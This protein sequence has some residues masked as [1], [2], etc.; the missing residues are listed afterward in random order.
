MAKKS[1]NKITS[2]HAVWSRDPLTNLP[3]A[4]ERVQDWIKE[5]FDSKAGVFYYDSTNNRFLV[6]ADEETRDTYLDNPSENASLLLG[7]FDAPFNYTASISLVDTNSVN[8][9][10]SGSTGNYIKAEFDVVNKS[11]SSVGENVN[12]T[13]TFRNGSAQTRLTRTVAYGSQLSLNI[14]EYLSVG[15]NVITIAAVGQNTLAATSIGL[16]YYCINLELND[17]FDI[18]QHISPTGNLDI[19]FNIVG[20]GIKRLQWYI[21]GV[22]VPYD[23]QN[24]DVTASEASRVKT[25]PLSSYGLSNGRHNLQYRAY[26]ETGDGS[27]FYS[28]TLYRDFIVD[29]GYLQDYLTVVAFDFPYSSDYGTDGIIDALTEPIPIYGATQYLSKD[30]KYAVNCPFGESMMKITLGSSASTYSVQNGNVYTYSLQSFVS[31]TTYLSFEVGTD[32]LEFNVSFEETSYSDLGEVT[33]GLVF[34]MDKGDSTNT[35]D[36]RNAWSYGSYSAVMTGFSW[37]DR[38]GWTRDG[39]LIPEGASFVTNYAPLAGN[40]VQTGFTAEFEFETQ[41]VLDD[42]EIICD[43]R[44]N[45]TGLLITASEASITSRGGVSVSTK[46]KSGVPLRVSFVI[47]PPTATRNKNLLFIY[48]DGI[49]AGAMNYPSSDS[50]TSASYL[51]FA[52]SADAAILLKQVR[53][54]N[55]AL[56]SNEILNNFILYRPTTQELVATYDRNDILDTNNQPSEDKLAAYTPIIIVTGDVEKLMNFDRSNKG[57]YVK[58][59]KIEIINNLDPTKN[60]TIVNA[61]MRCQ[62]TSSM[63]YPRK[64]FRFYL[65]KDSADTTVDSYATRVFDY[66]GNELT[67]GDRKYAFKEGAQPVS[68]WCLK[69]DYAESSST[70]NTGVARLWNTVMKNAVVNN[71]DSRHYVLDEYPSSKTPCRTLAQHAALAE[72]FDKDVRTTVD[73]F[74]IVLFYHKNESDALICLGKYNWNNDKSTESVYGFVD[75]PGFDDSNVECWEVVNGD[76]A[77]NQ[78]TDMT[79]WSAGANNGGWQDSFEA[80]Y[81]DDSGKASEATRAEGALKTVCFWIN[82]TNGASKVEDGEIV[83]DDA[84]LMSTF[85][86]EKWDHLDVYKVAAYYVYLMR[87]GGVD[88]TVKNAMFTTEDGIHWFY[89]NYDNDTI[90]GVRNDGL[91]KFGYSIDRQSKDPDN[92]NA[93]CYAGHDSVLWNNLEADTEFMAIVKV[94]DQALFDAGLTYVNVIKMFNEEQ[95]G[96]WSERLHNYDYT[97]KYLDVWL[98]DQNMQLEK[99]QGPRRTHRE[100]WLSNRFAIYDAKNMTGQ[101]LKSFVSIKPST[102][103]A[104]VSGDVVKVTPKVDGQVF[105]WRLGTNGTVYSENGVAGTEISFDLYAAGISYYIGGSLFFFNA[106]YMQKIDFSAIATHIQ[107]LS[108]AAVNSDVFPTYLEEIVV[109]DTNSVTNTSMSGVSNLGNVKYL[110]KF[111]MCNCTAV[112]NLDLSKNIYLEEVDLRGSTSL[113]AVSFPDAAPISTIKMPTSTQAFHGKDLVNLSTFSV[114][115]NGANLVDIRAI[116]C[117]PFTDSISWLKTWRT[118]KTDSFLEGCSVYLEGIDWLNVDVDDLI[119]LGKV[120]NLTLKGKIQATL[121]DD[122]EEE[123]AAL[124]AIYGEHCFDSTN[125]IWIYGETVYKSMS[126]PSSVVEGETAQYTFVVIGVPGSVRYFISGNSRPGVTINQ[127]TG[128]LS[129]TL[130]NEEDSTLTVRAEFTPT[131]TASSNYFV[132]TMTVTIKKET[133]PSDSDVTISGPNSFVDSQDKNFSAVIA[134]PETFTGINHITHNWTLTGDVATYFYIASQPAGS[135]SCVVS[136]SGGE[137]VVAE[138]TLTLSFVNSLGITVTQKEFPVVAMS[139]NIAVTRTTNPELMTVFWNAFGT[140][141]TR[142]ANKISNANY[143]TKFEASSFVASDLGDGTKNGSLFNGSGITHFDEIRHFVSLT[144]L[145]AH[146]FDGVTTLTGDMEL[147]VGITSVE[148]NTFSSANLTNLVGNGITSVTAATA[149]NFGVTKSI[150]F[151]NCESFG[152]SGSTSITFKNSLEELY[153]PKCTSFTGYT[154]ASFN[155]TTETRITVGDIHAMG[156]SPGAQLQFNGR[157]IMVVSSNCS[158]KSAAYYWKKTSNDNVSYNPIKSIEVE[159][160]VTIYAVRDGCLCNLTTNTVILAPYDF[161]G[162]SVPSGMTKIA[163]RCYAICPGITTFDTAGV[164]SVGDNAF[165]TDTNLEYVRLHGTADPKAFNNCSKLTTVGPYGGSGYD[166]EYDSDVTSLP[167]YQFGTSKSSISEVTVASTI[168]SLVTTGNFTLGGP[169]IKKIYF[170]R[171]TA[172]IINAN[173]WGNN[174]ITYTGYSTRND[175]VNEVHIPSGAT[176]YTGSTWELLTNSNHGFT[177]YS[178]L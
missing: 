89:I 72:G 114:D 23:S 86:A 21:D 157:I 174:N 11:G 142:T 135:L 143:I 147:P 122:P 66:Q 28:D 17:T 121:S 31:G 94:V 48:I 46:Y 34:A 62:G 98:D 88:Q 133:Y 108:F 4:G 15:T 78:F 40:V 85:S 36:D 79:N 68:C 52:G 74:P 95:S 153:L 158:S 54:Y 65:K 116:N 128:M 156:S 32:I 106:V 58:M 84:D 148:A 8:Y 168:T 57:T 140:N 99:L 134:D 144:A 172:P 92:A 19:A 7:T 39:L 97:F 96:K 73:G 150:R 178:D 104:S 77:I 2:K 154:F 131:D 155:P 38:S 112:A 75:I 136:F 146:L 3:Y 90:L 51:Q 5:Q 64:N 53:C 25:I 160:D 141:G 37:T 129:T 152:G 130:N 87:F 100:W 22:Q 16:T 20:S 12:V 101:Y 83:V 173:T 35:S 27:L 76:Y 126:G 9:I 50:F 1:Y 159:E 70:H 166:I 43:L 82:S 10:K 162:S 45:G 81:P 119:D 105:G 14:D 44:S 67:G 171:S 102:D 55:R 163:A 59:D 177:F 125:D 103:G 138:G 164:T 123:I 169:K 71:V 113:T 137:Y 93:Y 124:Q 120:G 69:A 29:N 110:R 41:R 26:V 167:L 6:F 175:G 170:L 33:N 56:S 30:V 176:G 47:N 118:G 18:S 63:D 165:G 49:L 132:E 107:E 149:G 80:R 161:S 13:I 151:P 61:S 139:G 111:Q 91:L 115:S 24:D 42:S 117:K 60:L 109:G 127:L 145:P